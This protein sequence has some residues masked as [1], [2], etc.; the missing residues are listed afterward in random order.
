VRGFDVKFETAPE[1]LEENAD[2]VISRFAAA[3]TQAVFTGAYRTT[4]FDQ[5]GQLPRACRW[6]TSASLPT[7]APAA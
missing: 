4:E 2:A 1:L 3:A 7:I 5:D 6:S